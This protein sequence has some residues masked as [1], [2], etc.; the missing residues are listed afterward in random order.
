MNH[1][2][3]MECYIDQN[4]LISLHLFTVP[5]LYSFCTK[6]FKARSHWHSTA[7]MDSFTFYTFS[8]LFTM[9]YNTL[10][11]FTSHSIHYIFHNPRI[12]Y[13][14]SISSH[15]LHHFTSLFTHWHPIYTR[16]HPFTSFTAPLHYLP[17]SISTKFI[18]HYIPWLHF[19]LFS[20]SL[21]QFS[22][23]WACLHGFLHS[24]KL[25][26]VNCKL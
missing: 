1:A 18:D 24:C 17:R 26:I 11:R 23:V 15:I 22:L 6:P 19:T 14:F 10:D 13:W 2:T 7:L 21:H 9:V 8:R 20:I 25:Y 4:H 3:W 16:F 12:L 5:F